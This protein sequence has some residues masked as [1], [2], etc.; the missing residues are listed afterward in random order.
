MSTA[1]EDRREQADILGF[2]EGEI[3]LERIEIAGHIKGQTETEGDTA[4]EIV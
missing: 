3:R 4:S 1:T 2:T